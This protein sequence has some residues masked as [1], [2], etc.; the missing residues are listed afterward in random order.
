MENIVNSDKPFVLFLIGSPGSGKTWLT[1]YLVYETLCKKKFNHVTV[2]SS[3]GDVN[4]NY[5]YMPD[6]RI[7]LEYSEELLKNIIKTQKDIGKESLL[8]LDDEVGKAD[9]HSKAFKHL[10]TTH[11]QWKL[12]II[13]CT[14]YLNTELPPILRN[15]ITHAIWFKQEQKRS[16][17]GLFE[18]FGQRF[19]N[20]K[21][22]QE[23]MKELAKYEFVLFDKNVDGMEAYN[24]LKAPKN[25]PEFKIDF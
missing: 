15:C 14:Q 20:E 19:S 5:S 9:F 25:I 23:Q 17:H 22:F 6:K 7:H 4:G 24:I 8:I 16:I 3:T 11:R 1:R 18:S 10:C 2:V 21:E 13:I 12:S